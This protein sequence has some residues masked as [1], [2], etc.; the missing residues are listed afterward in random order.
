MS[1]E[2]RAIAS[3]FL[4]ALALYLATRPRLGFNSDV[5]TYVD[6]IRSGDAR[7]LLNAHHLL[8]NPTGRVWLR[9]SDVLGVQARPDALLRVMNAVFGALAV[10]AFHR[11]S[12]RLLDGQV[13]R[14][15]ATA[16]FATCFAVWIFSVDVEVYVPSTL[17]LILSALALFRAR[18]GGGLGAA[19]VAG[20]LMGLGA[21]YHQ[22]GALFALP[23]AVLLCAPGRVERPLRHV[24]A[25][26]AAGGITT[27]LPYLFAAVTVHGAGSPRELLA[28][29]LGYSVRGY[30][31]GW[32]PASLPDLVLGHGRS[33]VFFGFVLRDLQ[34]GSPRVAAD[35]ALVALTGLGL[36]IGSVGAV[37]GWRRG[38]GERAAAVAFCAA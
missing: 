7:G 35:I 1:L 12:R 21:L 26:W 37:L 5:Y 34:A 36:A 30:G 24:S 22:M 16:G 4:A 32:T 15:L 19:V 18:D 9:L 6:T 33:L 29:A 38:L 27:L 23:G 13:E 10:A 31:A 28:F 8:Y 25:F 17:F 3:V 20:A 2:R 11:L 14:L